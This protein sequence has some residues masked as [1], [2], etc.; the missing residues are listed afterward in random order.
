MVILRSHELVDMDVEEL[1]GKLRELQEGLMKING[2]LA[3]GGIPEDIGE[4]REIKKTIARIKT[5][6]NQ[7]TTNKKK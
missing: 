3:S 2:V 7:K 6:K 4:T 5:I 1:D